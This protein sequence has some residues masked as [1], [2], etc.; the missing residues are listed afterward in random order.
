MLTKEIVCKIYPFSLVC[1][2]LDSAEKTGINTTD[3]ANIM[4]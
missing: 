2:V 4:C 3:N 1:Q